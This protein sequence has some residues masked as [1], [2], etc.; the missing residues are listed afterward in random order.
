MNRQQSTSISGKHHP[1]NARGEVNRACCAREA[2]SC[3]LPYHPSI[4]TGRAVMKVVRLRWHRLLLGVMDSG[5]VRRAG[6]EDD[7]ENELK[8]FVAVQRVGLPP[9]KGA[10]R[11][12]EASLARVRQRH[13]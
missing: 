9:G 7:R 3:L 4:S 10:A 12:P 1:E 11:Q 6:E 5:S 13:A 8:P 2:R